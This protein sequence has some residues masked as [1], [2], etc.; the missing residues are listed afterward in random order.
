MSELQAKYNAK[1]RAKPTHPESEFQRNL[2]K[3]FRLA[4]AKYRTLFFAIPNGGKR[5]EI[6]AKIMAGEG[7]TPGIPDT[8]L[9]VPRGGYHALFIEL[10]V[11]GRKCSDAQEARQTE[12]LGQ[13]YA[14]A[15]CW[16]IDEA[17]KDINDYLS[18]LWVRK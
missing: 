9:A 18:G 1:Q 5:S 3:W 4:H 11:K 10:K 2:V 15:V 14:V 17:M 12:L 8:L 6:E 13:G 16:D 7:V